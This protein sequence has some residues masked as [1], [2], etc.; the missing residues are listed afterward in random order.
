[1]RTLLLVLALALAVIAPASAQELAPGQSRVRVILARQSREI[2]GAARPQ[3]LRGTLLSLGPDSL[4]IQ[5]HPSSTPLHLSNDAVR[6]IYLSRGVPNR[7]Q[8]ALAGAA[9]TAVV[10]A[11]RFWITERHHFS[12]GRDAL[13]TGGAVGAGFGLVMGAAFPQE[14]WKRIRLPR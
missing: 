5:V 4:A 7:A 12:S 10:G 13:L 14:R 8:S 3:V 2:E 6:R 9:A 11:L 1:M